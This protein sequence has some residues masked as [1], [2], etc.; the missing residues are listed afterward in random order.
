[1]IKLKLTLILCV[2]LFSSCIIQK[3]VHINIKDSS[4]ISIDSAISGSDLEDLKPSLELPL[5]P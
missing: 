3:E 1:M 4:Y 2:F 5:I